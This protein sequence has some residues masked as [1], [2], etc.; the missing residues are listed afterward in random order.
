MEERTTILE[1]AKF[2][3]DDPNSKVRE[4]EMRS[5]TTEGVSF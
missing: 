4:F 3:S 5:D 1:Q 2:E